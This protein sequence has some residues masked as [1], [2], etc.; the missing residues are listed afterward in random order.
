MMLGDNQRRWQSWSSTKDSLSSPHSL[1]STASAKV[2][3]ASEQK[4]ALP[5]ESSWSHALRPHAEGEIGPTNHGNG[6]HG[7]ANA[8]GAETTGH[9]D[10]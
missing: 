10:F 2:H 3:G 5:N 7:R 6:L 1:S 4:R 8:P 9:I